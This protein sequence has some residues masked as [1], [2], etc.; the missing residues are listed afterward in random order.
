MIEHLPAALSS[1]QTAMSVGKAMLDINDT[2]KGQD[3]LIEFNGAII[4]AQQLIISAQQDQT[5]LLSEIDELKKKNEELLQWKED[6]S[7]YVRTEVGHG[8]FAYIEKNHD[9]KLM[10]THK[11][12]CNCFENNKKSTLQQFYVREG[13][14]IGLKCPNG[15]PDIVFHAY[16]D[17][18]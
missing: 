10:N 15:C 4:S 6:S 16:M 3:K 2:V 17:E 12:C 9:G 7:N 11:F 1:L 13:R 18:Y 14:Q 5:T 8:V